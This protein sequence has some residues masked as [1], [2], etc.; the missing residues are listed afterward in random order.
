MAEF[1]DSSSFL[2][3]IPPLDQVDLGAIVVH[4][5]SL[6]PAKDAHWLNGSKGAF[7]WISPNKL[8]VGINISLQR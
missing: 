8:V 1:V 3:V 4:R 6:Q 2:V 5:P 7:N